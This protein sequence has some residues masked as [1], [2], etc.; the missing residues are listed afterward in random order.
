MIGHHALV[1]RILKKPNDEEHNREKIKRD[2]FLYLDSN[3]K[4]FAQCGTCWLFHAE[5]ERCA[6]LG[7][8]FVV[9]DDDSCCFYIKGEVPKDLKL[10]KRVT[11]KDAGFVERAVRCENCLYGG[12]GE[13][14]LYKMLNEK[15]P[16]VFDLDEQI[17]PRACCNANTPR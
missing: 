7:P 17:E 16:D 15:F 12:S 3:D 11:P 6:I 2:A 8:D 4:E 5:K 1:I 14:K 9:D 13:C 10:V